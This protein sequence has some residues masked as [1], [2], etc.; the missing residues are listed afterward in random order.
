MKF[1]KGTVISKAPR[2]SVQKKLSARQFLPLG[3]MLFSTVPSWTIASE[4]V[5]EEVVVSASVVQ[6]LNLDSVTN[7]GS[8][9]GLSSFETPAAIDMIDSSTMAM[10]GIKSVTEAAESLVGVLSGEAPGEPSSFSMRGFQQNQISVLRDGFRAGPAN[11]TMRPQNS[12][13]LERVE[14]LKGP[15]AVLYGEGAV[16]GTVNMVTKRPKL[17]GVTA[18]EFLLSYGRYSSAEVGFGIGGPISDSVAYRVDV[19]RSSSSGWVDSSSSKSL[20]ITGS[21]LW[22][23]NE[24]LE[25]TASIDYLQ[26]ELP[27][28]WGTPLVTGEFAGSNKISGVIDSDQNLAVDK[29]MR[30][31]NYNVEDFLSESDHVWGR[32]KVD[33]KL[34]ENVSITNEAFKFTA[35]RDWQNAEQYPFN[36]TTELIDRDRFFVHHDQDLYGN[37]FNLNVNNIFGGVENSF[38][39][40]FDYSNLYFARDRGFPYGDSVDPL[41]PVAGFFGD[42]V[43]K[44]APTQIDTL[45]VFFE[46]SIKLSEQFRVVFGARLDQMELI[47][48]NFNFDGSFNEDQSFERDFSSLGWRAGAVYTIAPSLVVYGQYATGEDPVGSNIFLVNANQNFDLTSAYQWEIGLKASLADGRVQFTAAYYDI[49]REDILT[50]ISTTQV[51][52]VGDQGS[53]GI[54]FSFAF[55]AAENWSIGGN[56]AYTNAS[57]GTF[58]DPNFGIDASGNRPPN[59]AENT[60]NMWTSLSNIWG[61]P[62]EIGGGLRHVGD[63][64]ANSAND[65]EL[66]A[67]TTIDAFVAYE[68]ASSRIMLRVKNATDEVYSPWADIFYPNQIVLASPRTVEISVHSEF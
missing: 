60:A 7:T 61:L 13:N 15:S 57:Y 51:S 59:V 24:N 19:D 27:S 2:L 62:L 12:F 6:R 49:E 8:R 22:A 3:G 38:V 16:A 53:K 1:S 23:A 43:A 48:D 42:R 56:Y 36:P 20:N 35:E 25:V 68:V 44:S 64:F 21:V 45:A 31:V 4:P 65:V 9:L 67:Y 50:Q 33:W 37:R 54:E 52:D 17:D 55:D 29:R 46:D 32:L 26:D 30:F 39:I 63:R 58:V 14:I 66:L 28:Y 18:G 34:N 47:R 11:M 5:L 10:R 40:G 41:N